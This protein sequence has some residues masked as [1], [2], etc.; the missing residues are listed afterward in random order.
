MSDFN[1][2]SYLEQ[3]HRDARDDAK[4]IRAAFDAHEKSD[5]EQFRDI[6]TNLTKL[7]ETRDFVKWMSR[8]VGGGALLGIVDLVLHLFKWKP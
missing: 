1:L 5:S 6:T 3:M 8:L 7:N 2:Q 4:G